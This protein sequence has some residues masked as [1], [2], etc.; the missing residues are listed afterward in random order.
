MWSGYRS[1]IGSWVANRLSRIF[2]LDVLLSKSWEVQWSVIWLCVLICLLARFALIQRGL[3]GYSSELDEL[4]EGSVALQQILSLLEQLGKLALL[5]LALH[6]T[7]SKKVTT[8]AWLA[9]YAILLSEMFFGLTK[10]FKSEVVLPPLLILITYYTVRGRMPLAWIAVVLVSIPIAYF[11]IEPFRDAR[12]FDPKFDNRS[13]LSITKFLFES[14]SSEENKADED[15]G[16]SG[17][18]RVMGRLNITLWS[19]AAIHLDETVGLDENAPD[20]LTNL[21]LQPAYSVIPRLIWPDKPMQDY[22]RWFSREVFEVR[23]AKTSTAFGLVGHLYF[24][25]GVLGVCLGFFAIGIA[26]RM[27]YD[28]FWRPRAGSLLIYLVIVG[29]IARTESSVDP[30]IAVF[31]RILPVLVICQYFIYK[32][33]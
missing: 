25:G 7:G 18:S 9:L 17:P 11:F 32:R 13:L 8:F 2:R 20:F 22:G 16:R 28:A 31:I 29:S 30:I 4:D 15:G 19:A 23:E 10:G 12:N 3:Y 5:A 21:V 14:I 6:C 24:A 1:Q 27:V 26:Q 33:S